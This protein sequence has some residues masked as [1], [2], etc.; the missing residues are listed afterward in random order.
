MSISDMYTSGLQKK[1]LIH[2]AA[3]ANIAAVDGEINLEEEKLLRKFANKLDIDEP[4]YKEVLKNPKGFPIPSL[5]HKDERLEYIFELF[6]M[7]YVDHEIDEPEAKLIYKYAIGLGCTETRAKDVI[8]KSI[9]I[10]GGGLDFEDYQYLIN[11]N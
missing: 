1:N 10:F 5:N 4:H 3:I 11:K 7:I 6:Q 8:A 2:F 9:K